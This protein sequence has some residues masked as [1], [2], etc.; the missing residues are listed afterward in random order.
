MSR[1]LIIEWT[2]EDEAFWRRKGRNIALQNLWISI[3]ALTLA[4]AVWMVWSVV[5]VKLPAV[6][7]KFSTNQLFW[8]A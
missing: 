1:N 3:P 2:P 5:V 4:F 6:G 7:F 8:L